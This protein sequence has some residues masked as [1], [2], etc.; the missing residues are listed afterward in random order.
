MHLE[1]LGIHSLR[2]VNADKWKDVKVFIFV[3]FLTVIPGV[4][5]GTKCSLQLPLYQI[6]ED[7]F[8]FKGLLGFILIM[9]FACGGSL[10]LAILLMFKLQNLPKA[11]LQLSLMSQ[12]TILM[13]LFSWDCVDALAHL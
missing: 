4:S 9:Y 5:R 6:T 2:G 1:R 12:E 3:A 7:T 13:L 11:Y 10:L 8:P